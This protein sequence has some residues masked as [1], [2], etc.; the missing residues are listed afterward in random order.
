MPIEVKLQDFARKVLLFAAVLTVVALF[1][2]IW[3]RWGGLVD[4]NSWRDTF[5]YYV[6]PL[7]V[8]AAAFTF[9]ALYPGIDRLFVLVIV[10]AVY[11][12][13]VSADIYFDYASRDAEGL[14]RAAAARFK[15][16]YDDRDQADV[17]A[18]LRK[19]GERAFAFVRELSD[20]NLVTLGVLP[21]SIAVT[22]N[23][24]G[25]WFIPR[26]D[27]YG[28]VNP[29]A[30]W[31]QQQ[32][33]DAVIIGDS[34][35]MGE[36][37]PTTGGFAT[38]LRNGGRSILNLG[39]GGN[40]PLQDLASLVE[41]GSTRKARVIFWMHYA[42]NDLSGLVQ[43]RIYPILRRY[44]N[45][46]AFRQDLM[47]RMPEVEKR[48]LELE[49]EAYQYA[50][51]TSFVSHLFAYDGLPRSLR[52][53]VLRSAFGMARNTEADT[54]FG[55][56]AR[57]LARAKETAVGMGAKL[58]IVNIPAVAQFGRDS[59]FERATSAAVKEAGLDFIDLKP[60]FSKTGDYGALYSHG[61]QGGHFSPAGNRLAA[62]VLSSV[63]T[64]GSR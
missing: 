41:F 16:P 8:T 24:F 55:L 1:Y 62:Q 12:A 31:D 35:A 34:Y 6:V 13:L 4:A 38:L 32:P 36:C 7:V 20:S 63:V 23:E 3:N 59:A 46:P 27:R 53:Y 15:L 57:V 11:V 22:C 33:V 18:D 39:I 49:P 50:S 40:D 5:L 17:V 51:Q 54:D 2:A 10:A 44:V 30:I 64:A 19:K 61:V 42:G 37:D 45:D 47:H 52:L 48:L 43:H 14:N 26:T 58:Y 9:A 28:F 21:N 60:I 29:D 25:P 56:F